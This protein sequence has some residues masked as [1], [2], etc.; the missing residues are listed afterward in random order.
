MTRDPRAVLALLLATTG[1][2][3]GVR[4]RR[5][6]QLILRRSPGLWKQRS[7]SGLKVVGLAELPVPPESAEL[8]LDLTGSAAR[9]RERTKKMMHLE[10]SS[11]SAR[12]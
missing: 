9:R 12:G 8:D 2:T 7:N 5:R 10:L 11:S 4:A 1:L 6:L 3:Q